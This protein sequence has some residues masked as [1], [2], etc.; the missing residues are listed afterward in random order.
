MMIVETL[1]SLGVAFTSNP[2]SSQTQ[3]GKIL[4]LAAIG[5]QII[6]IM[7][8]FC[9]AGIFHWRC[10]KNGIR[11]KAVPALPIVMYV[12]MFLILIRS[13]YRMVEHAGNSALDVYDLEKL[14]S[15]SPLLRYEWYFFV[16]EGA[17]MLA[18]SLLWN[19]WHAS[20]YL[21]QSRTVF[22]AEDGVTEITWEEESI[23]DRPTLAKA[24]HGAMTILTLGVSAY[25]FP[26]KQQNE[27]HLKQNK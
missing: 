20:R 3:A 26:Q 16:F 9:L 7:A 8:F 2:T 6:L 18:N 19:V 5:I 21:P 22:I 25:I 4:V 27:K 13:V 14:Q 17:T 23:G 15:L 24:T 12:S 10:S 1:N 11:I